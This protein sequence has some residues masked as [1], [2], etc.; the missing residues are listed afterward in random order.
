M[1]TWSGAIDDWLQQNTQPSVMVNSTDNHDVYRDVACTAAG[2]AF[3]VV[4]VEG[5]VDTIES[6]SV[7]GDLLDWNLNGT[8]DIEATW[9]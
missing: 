9:E 8:V 5:Q 6:Y 1:S 2:N 7:E 3:A 4:T